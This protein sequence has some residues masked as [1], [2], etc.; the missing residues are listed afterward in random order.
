V[1]RHIPA[2]AAGAAALFAGALLAV[3]VVHVKHAGRDVRGSSTVEF[4]PPPTTGRPR[5]QPARRP[6]VAWSTYGFDNARRRADDTSR[7]RPP[8]RP[9]WTFRSGVLLEF[10]P[11]VDGGR[12]Y[13]PT[14]DGRFFALAASTG[15]VVWR[16]GSGRCGWAS[17]AIAAGL[18]YVTFIG[19]RRTCGADVPGPDGDVVAFDAATG[20]VRWL[21]R[22]APTESSPLVAGGLVYVGDWSGT[23]WALDARTGRTRWTFRTSGAVKGSTASSGG[24][25]FMG[26]YNGRIYAL[27]ARNGRLRWRSSAQPRLGA[28]GAFYSTP[29]IAYGRVYIGSTDG[30]VYS[31]GA[32]SGKLRW[33]RSTGGY[34]YASPAVWRG[35]V[36]VG[37]YDHRFYAFDAATGETRWTFAA[38]GSIS[39]AASVIDGVVYFST[40]AD[41][42]YA[43]AAET[44]RLLWSWP[45]GHYSP[46]VAD[47]SRLYVV[48]LGRLYGMV[49]K[50][51]PAAHG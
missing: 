2:L 40:F 49:S 27:D 11:A 15:R 33:S 46:A 47:E 31:F 13:L 38:N 50:R 24:T 39:G 51:R 4:T 3:H 17:P 42:T 23:E 48:G 41:R 29:A 22:L 36:L 18:V 14:F 10:P 45:D 1:R 44:G 43:L 16:Y 34:V 5:K 21:R 6:E 9:V 7:L 8:F 30:K 35:L 19:R 25:L 28:R 12:V 20:A 26:D 32:A 37:S